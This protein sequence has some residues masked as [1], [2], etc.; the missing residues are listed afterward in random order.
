MA[1]M[2]ERSKKVMEEMKK[3]MGKNK[4]TFWYAPD[5]TIIKMEFYM[6][7]KLITR[8]EVTGIKK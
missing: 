7:D 6:G 1:G 3:K 8:S 2:D 5:V 4:M